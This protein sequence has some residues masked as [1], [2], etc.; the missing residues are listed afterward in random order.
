MTP[1]DLSGVSQDRPIEVL[2]FEDDPAD[3]LIVERALLH[4]SQQQQLNDKKPR[5]RAIVC[6]HAFTSNGGWSGARP[7]DGDFFSGAHQPRGMM[8]DLEGVAVMY[9]SGN[10]GRML[11]F[12]RLGILPFFVMAAWIV[13]LWARRHFGAATG[14]LAVG[15]FG[16]VPTVLA[17]A[18][19]ATTD[20][21]LT[22]CLAAAFFAMREGLLPE[23]E[24]PTRVA[25]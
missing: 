19:L 3:A 25:A 11:T 18:G 2:N 22:A 6:H 24:F 14:A 8:Q 9:H 10:P 5:L 1:L 16:L 7:L 23:E 20:M 4:A 21:P 15:L 12:M 17:H 13:Y